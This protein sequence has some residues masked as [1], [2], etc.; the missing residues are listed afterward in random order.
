MT[1]AL[2]AL[3]QLTD[4]LSSGQLSIPGDLM[5]GPDA[6]KLAVTLFWLVVSI[7][8]RIFSPLNASRPSL[9]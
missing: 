1:G 2:W 3:Q 6:A 4:A 8:S 7:K 9:K 5:P